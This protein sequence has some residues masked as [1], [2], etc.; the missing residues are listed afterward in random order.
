MDRNMVRQ[1][2]SDEQVAQ[3]SAGGQNQRRKLHLCSHHSLSPLILQLSD[4][5][6]GRAADL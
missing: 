1:I 5:Q 4:G 2:L 3:I 6:I